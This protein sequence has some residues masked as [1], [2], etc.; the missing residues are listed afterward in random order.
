MASKK[1]GTPVLCLGIVL[2]LGIALGGCFLTKKQNRRII[3]ATTTST[4]NSGLL[5]YLLP[6]FTK[7]TGIAVDVVAVGTGK[8]LALGQNGDADVILVHAPDREK[9]YVEQGYGIERR[10]V[11]YNDFILVGPPSDPAGVL[12]SKDVAEAMKKIAEGKAPF[13][14]RGDDSGTHTK[15]QKL[16]ERAGIPAVGKWYKEVG[17]GMG[18]TLTITSES[19]GYTLADRGTWLSMKNLDLKI[20][21]EGDPILFNPYGIMVVNPKLHPHVK[22]KE[23]RAFIEWMTGTK[24]QNLIG[25]FKVNGQQL[26]VP[27]AR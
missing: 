9:K 23:A 7:T 22:L 21:R 19:R 25:Q 2:A 4:D 26:F 16:W 6:I 3:L 14:S 18:A 13:L 10:K 8:A 27:N 12:Q 17:Q 5:N 1:T 15:E 24:A 11:M 20:V